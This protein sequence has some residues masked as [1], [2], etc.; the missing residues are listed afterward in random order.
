LGSALE[1]VESREHFE[2][3]LEPVLL[4][5]TTPHG[6]RDERGQTETEA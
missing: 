4:L 1:R 3:G 2:P 5:D 6:V